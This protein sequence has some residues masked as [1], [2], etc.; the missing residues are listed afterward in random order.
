M[1]YGLI[2]GRHTMPV[3]GYIFKES[4]DPFNFHYWENEAK[5]FFDNYE[6]KSI[7]VYVSGFT[8]ALVEV[9]KAGTKAGVVIKLEHYN[10]ETGEYDLQRFN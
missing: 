3:Q 8:P 2:E 9:L 7:K 6:E 10:T 5:K 4:K 1:K